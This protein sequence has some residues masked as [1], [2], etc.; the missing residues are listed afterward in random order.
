MIL[1]NRY[2]YINIFSLRSS[3]TPR[4]NKKKVLYYTHQNKR[5]GG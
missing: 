4:L 3:I 5:L 2:K 1:I